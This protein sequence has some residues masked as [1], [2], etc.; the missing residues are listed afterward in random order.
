MRSAAAQCE[1][2]GPLITGPMASLKMLG[3]FWVA[4]RVFLS[5]I[6]D[7]VCYSSALIL[8]EIIPLDVAF[9]K[10]ARQVASAHQ[11][12]YNA[13]DRAERYH[14]EHTGGDMPIQRV[15]L[16]VFSGTGNTA[17]VAGHI[18]QAFRSQ[19]VPVEVIRIEDV[20]R[21]MCSLDV[22]AFDLIG[23]GHPIYGFD[24]PRN[25][26]AF[27]RAL[28]VAHAKRVF[29]FKSAG[30]FI[31]INHSA[32]SRLIRRLRRKGYDVTYD[33]I[34]AMPSNWAV[35]YPDALSRALCRVL[36][37]K[38]AHMVRDVLAGTVRRLPVNPLWRF[39][40]RS[41]HF[42]EEWGA[43]L[44]GRLL[45]ASDA[46]ARCGHCVDVCPTG[47][48][49]QEGERIVFGWNCLWCMRCIYACPQ[50]ALR[51]RLFRCAAIKGGYDLDEIVAEATDGSGES[52]EPCSEIYRGYYAH[53]Q[54]YVERVEI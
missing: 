5:L 43:R 34:F 42:W 46:C 13:R 32:S 39:A 22:K 50:Q 21:G 49:R 33:R 38:T 53:F 47:N 52:V 14:V 12:R 40:V 2:D 51:P 23:I 20:L 25:I 45:H 26:Y 4:G 29:L 28:P 11:V 6:A 31:R 30:D 9:E 35:R 37:A 36:P 17:W 44:F 24:A 10:C 3:M 15:G 27:I 16:F 18:A 1:L 48:I 19:H 41:S 8:T 54:R 7:S